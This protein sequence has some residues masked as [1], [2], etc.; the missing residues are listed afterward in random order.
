MESFCASALHSDVFPVPGGP[1][2]FEAIIQSSS[3][4]N[5]ICLHIYP[6]PYLYSLS[7][8]LFLSIHQPVSKYG[9]QPSSIAPLMCLSFSLS[10]HPS[11]QLAWNLYLSIPLTNY[12]LL[13]LQYITR[14]FCPSVTKFSLLY[15]YTSIY[16]LNMCLSIL[17]YPSIID[18]FPVHPSLNCSIYSVHMGPLLRHQYVPI[19]PS[20]PVSIYF[21]LYH[22]SIYSHLS[23][24]PI[25]F[26]SIH[27]CQ[28]DP[29][30]SIYS[31]GSLNLFM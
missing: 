16:I 4:N 8:C 3:Q 14:Y 10:P 17:S 5:K 15:F 28:S 31:Y 1:V 26:L 25:S 11:P 19:C 9:L 21:P 2:A 23:I 12:K 18:Q 27:S 30:S 29:A 13:Y 24:F 20:I 7:V 22:L 6:S